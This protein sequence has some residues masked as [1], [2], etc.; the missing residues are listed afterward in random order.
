MRDLVIFAI[1]LV[2]SFSIKAQNQIEG[3]VLELTNDGEKI[4]IFG[5]NV[6]WEETNIGTT[7]DVNG[8]YFISEAKSFPATLS[9]SYI[10]YTFDKSHSSNQISHNNC[11]VSS[12]NYQLCRGQC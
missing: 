6:Y 10:G 7:T 5:A 3:R 4:P 12:R 8:I 1:V 2:A 9:V 11:S